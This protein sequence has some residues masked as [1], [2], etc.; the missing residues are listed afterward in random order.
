M[1]MCPTEPSKQPWEADEDTDSLQGEA[2]GPEATRLW[3]HDVPTP[4]PT[5][6]LSPGG[7]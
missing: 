3:N 6:L 4:Y 7:C 2:A 5:P 1:Q